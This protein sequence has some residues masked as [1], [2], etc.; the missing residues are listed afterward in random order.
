[1]KTL[2]DCFINEAKQIEYRVC[3]DACVNEKMD[4]LPINV[5][6]FVDNDDVESFEKYLNDEQDNIFVHASGGNVEYQYNNMKNY[7]E[8]FQKEIRTILSYFVGAT[9][10]QS[11]KNANV[12]IKTQEIVD[13]YIR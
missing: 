3:F 2:K 7:L 6:I 4:N 11:I 10:T 1:M 13:K 9:N 8:E 5:S 12:K